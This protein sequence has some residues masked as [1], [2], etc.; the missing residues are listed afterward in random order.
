MRAGFCRQLPAFGRVLQARLYRFHRR[1][2]CRVSGWGFREEIQMSDAIVTARPSSGLSFGTATTILVA[3]LVLAV[4][5][6]W[7]AGSLYG[8]DKGVASNAF[9]LVFTVIYAS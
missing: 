1:G 5:V 7:A 3:L 4:P 6:C 9:W 8:V 2:Q